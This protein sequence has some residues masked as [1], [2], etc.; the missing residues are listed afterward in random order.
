MEQ[1]GPVTVVVRHRVKPGREADFEAWQRGINAASLRFPGHMGFHVVRPHD[2]RKPEFMVLFK[3]DT[4]DNLERWEAS[5]ERGEWLERLGPLVAELPVRERHTGMEVWFDPPRGRVAPP[6]LKMAVV[7]LLT[8]YPLILLVALFVAPL[9]ADWP[10]PFRALTSTS[11]LVVTM[12]YLA[13]PLSTRVLGRWLY[14][15]TV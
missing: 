12:T 13:M 6:R 8:L 14:G 2:P 5:D 1:D 7:T 15:P 10:L 11:L 9:I 3:F 4:L